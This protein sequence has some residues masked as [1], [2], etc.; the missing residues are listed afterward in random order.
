MHNKKILIFK[1]FVIIIIF[2]YN[3]SDIKEDEK[4]FYFN[5]LYIF[6]LLANG[7]WIREYGGH[8]KL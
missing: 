2:V 7:R 6:N 5:R 1:E 4:E 3:L 8:L